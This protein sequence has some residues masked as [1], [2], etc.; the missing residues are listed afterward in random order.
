MPREKV[1]TRVVAHLP[2]AEA[3]EQHADALA[4]FGSRY[5]RAKSVRFS[6]GVSSR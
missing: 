6:S 3:L 4:A 5:S 1:E 2:Q